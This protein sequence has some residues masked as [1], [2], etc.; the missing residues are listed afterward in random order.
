[1]SIESGRIDMARRDSR[2]GRPM[3]LARGSDRGFV[4]CEQARKV[5]QK[6]SHLVPAIFARGQVNAPRPRAS[7]FIS[8]DLFWCEAGSADPLDERPGKCVR[9]STEM[10][11]EFVRAEERVAPV[12]VGAAV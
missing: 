12:D 10:E 3:S 11:G 1:M 9:Q 4:A 7:I 8:T 5:A 6:V 2:C